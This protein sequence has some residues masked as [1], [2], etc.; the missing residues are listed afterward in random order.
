MLDTAKDDGSMGAPCSFDDSQLIDYLTHVA[1]ADARQAIESSPACLEAAARL[2]ETVLPLMSLMYRAECPDPD[3]IVGY[4]DQQLPSTAQ[5]VVHAHVATCALCQAEIELLRAINRTPLVP[6][7]GRIRRMVEAMFQPALA[8]AVR[9]PLLR[10]Q[11][12]TITVHLG[13][14]KTSGR[15]RAWNVRGEVRTHDGERIIDALESASL[16]PIEPLPADE[17]QEYDATIEPTGDFVFRMIPPGTYQLRLITPE[18]EILI[19]RIEIDS[20]V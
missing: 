13:T 19:R 16:R 18:E 14:R 20:E 15:A 4:Q 2:A 10:Y 8:Q 11:T 5:L 12:P 3:T 9:G 17:I 6:A 1:S 7:P